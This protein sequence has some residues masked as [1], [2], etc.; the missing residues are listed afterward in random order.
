MRVCAFSLRKIQI[1]I[2][3]TGNITGIQIYLTG[4]WFKY[5]NAMRGYTY[6]TYT[7]YN[8]SIMV[9]AANIC[10]LKQIFPFKIQ[11]YKDAR[12]SNF[13]VQIQNNYENMNEN[14][15]FLNSL[16]Y[17]ADISCCRNSSFNECKNN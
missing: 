17:Y 4:F 9:F 14:L 13:D 7:T 2:G 15:L 10:K 11:E 5:I 3:I 1:Q 8:T 16:L 12:F 6:R